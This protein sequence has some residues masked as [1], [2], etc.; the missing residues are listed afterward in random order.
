[1]TVSTP[2]K[3]P[4]RPALPLESKEEDYAYVSPTTGDSK[5]TMVESRK[6][7]PPGYS[8][9]AGRGVAPR[10][11]K[12]MK[13]GILPP[14]I[15]IVP[16]INSE[17]KRFF[18]SAAGTAS[19]I[20]IG[21]IAGCL[22]GICT[23][24][25][26]TL[27]CWASSFRLRHIDVY[28]AANPTGGPPAQVGVEWSVGLSTFIPDKA[29][30]TVLPAGITVAQKLR[31]VPPKQALCGDWIN[32][33]GVANTIAFVTTNLNEGAIIDVCL[34]WTC[35]VVVST[36]GTLTQ[37]S[38]VTGTVGNVYYLALDGPSS[39]KLQPVVGLPTTH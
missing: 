28:P 24:L 25:N 19:S 18:N 16:T 35:G 7:L 33:N 23:A 14:A 38:I 13:G 12:G 31:F 11:K 36:V 9:V 8:L 1:M 30:N 5:K 29:V 10:G 15:N 27:S 34:D 37:V 21:D 32:V 2:S 26:T 4:R 39:N 6:L 17:V 20:T 3:G 22:G